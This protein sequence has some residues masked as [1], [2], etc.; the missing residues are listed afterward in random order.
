V[1][2]SFRSVSGCINE[3]WLA[4]ARYLLDGAGAQSGYTHLW[5]TDSDLDFRLFDFCCLSCP[6]GVPRALPQPASDSASGKSGASLGSHEPRDPV[7]A[8]K[9]RRRRKADARGARTHA[10]Y[11]E[12]SLAPFDKRHR[13]GKG[14]LWSQSPVGG[15]GKYVP[16][17]RC[18]SSARAV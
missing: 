5:K 15:C 14:V 1:H 6:A 7:C 11:G 17:R 12:R 13:L 2:R 8:R 18:A 10:P 3:G 9:I 4:A 16:L